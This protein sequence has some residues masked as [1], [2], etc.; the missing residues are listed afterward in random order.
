MD[1]QKKYEDLEFLYAWLDDAKKQN[2]TL[3][4]EYIT[5]RIKYLENE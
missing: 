2:K 1:I 4:I 3:E 5:N